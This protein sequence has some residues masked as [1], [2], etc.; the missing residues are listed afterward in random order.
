MAL[1][2]GAIFA[3]FI[4]SDNI[5]YVNLKFIGAF[6]PGAFGENPL[7]SSANANQNKARIS[8]IVSNAILAQI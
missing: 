3:S 8:P 5:Y 7:P 1:P 2:G 6:F 4:T